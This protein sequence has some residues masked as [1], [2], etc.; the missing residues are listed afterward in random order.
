[1]AIVATRLVRAS[2]AGPSKTRA[3]MV[4]LR[5]A[6]GGS[7]A[8]APVLLVNVHTFDA[9]RND[10]PWTRRRSRCLRSHDPSPHRTGMLRGGQAL[11]PRR[12]PRSVTDG[13]DP[14]WRDPWCHSR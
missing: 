14:S 9:C 10:V 11:S 5:G 1:M 8:M 4:A 7:F 3:R 13:I 2:G 12:H 6:H